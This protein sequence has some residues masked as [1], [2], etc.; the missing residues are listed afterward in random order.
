MLLA[1]PCK[2]K[3]KKRLSLTLLA[4]RGFLQLFALV[5]DESPV[6]PLFTGRLPNFLPEFGKVIPIEQIWQTVMWLCCSLQPLY[7]LPLFLSTTSKVTCGGH[8]H[9]N[10][11]TAKMW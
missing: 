3:G 9:L 7:S 6:W 8:K 4:G 11:V 1:L 10:D 2:G 5:A